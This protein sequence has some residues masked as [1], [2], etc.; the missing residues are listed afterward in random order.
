MHTRRVHLTPHRSK[1]HR[2]PRLSPII[3]AVT[4]LEARCASD[5]PVRQR[6]VIPLRAHQALGD[7]L[8]T[9][10]GCAYAPGR[11]C[12]TLRLRRRAGFCAVPTL[13]TTGAVVDVA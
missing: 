12:F 13:G 2:V 11:A 10:G 7:E 1:R 3:Y 9:R 8:E 5:R 6:L 4:T